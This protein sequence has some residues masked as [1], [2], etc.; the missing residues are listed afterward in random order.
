MR[1][2]T[3]PGN[4]GAGTGWLQLIGGTVIGFAVIFGLMTMLRVAELGPA[5]GRLTG[6]LR[7]R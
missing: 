6:L 7:R 4:A 5:I 1:V 2:L 3:S